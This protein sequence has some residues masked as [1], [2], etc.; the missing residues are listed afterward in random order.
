MGGFRP[1]QVHLVRVVMPA[2]GAEETDAVA[3]LLR[4][5][6]DGAA[7]EVEGAVPGTDSGEV[8]VSTTDLRRMIPTVRAAL[9]GVDLPDDSH[10]LVQMGDLDPER[11]ELR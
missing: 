9:H 3:D 8:W 10:L 6:L 5:R 4:V 11:F 1:E 2:A 7:G